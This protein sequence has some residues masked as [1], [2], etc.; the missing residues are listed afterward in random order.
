MSVIFLSSF[1]FILCF[2]LTPIVRHTFGVMGI[3]D[4]PHG[5]RKIHSVPIPRVGGIAVMG[6]YLGTFVLMLFLPVGVRGLMEANRPFMIHL[7]PAGA[8]I[9]VVGLADDLM[10]LKPWQKL[11]GQVAASG[12]AYWGG[13]RILHIAEYSIPAW[14]SLP[15]TIF[16]LVVCSNAFNLIDGADGIAAG[17]GFF[18]TVTM[19]LIGLLQHH[20]TLLIATIPLAGCLLAF[21]AYNFSPASIFLGDCGSLSIGFLLGCG[22]VLWG[23]KSAT[24][25]GMAAPL[26]AMAIPL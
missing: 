14:F 6:A 9:F 11:L 26:M 15:L 10:D 23:Q 19:V 17:V 25:L 2:I 5:I 7:L 4:R 16:W 3:V 8:L 12:L 21:L 22:A 20:F 18:A 1:A 13:V 24:L